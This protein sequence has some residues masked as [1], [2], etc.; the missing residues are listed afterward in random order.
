M[1]NFSINQRK[2]LRMMKTGWNILLQADQSVVLTRL[3]PR[4]VVSLNHNVFK[5][6]KDNGFITIKSEGSFSTTYA[7]TKKGL[8][9]LG[10]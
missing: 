7:V 1:T 6:L 9:W 4:R 5:S 8:N 3:R 2:A 10:E